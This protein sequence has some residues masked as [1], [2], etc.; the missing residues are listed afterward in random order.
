M[1]ISSNC[2]LD[3]I[4][5]KP[6]SIEIGMLPHA[7]QSVISTCIFIMRHSTVNVRGSDG[8]Q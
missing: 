5:R 6:Y 3:L 8:Y 2:L 7:D 4:E 1:R